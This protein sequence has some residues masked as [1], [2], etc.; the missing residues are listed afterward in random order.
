MLMKLV[1]GLEVSTDVIM[2]GVCEGSI[3]PGRPVVA[4]GEGDFDCD[5]ISDS[6]QAPIRDE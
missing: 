5:H 1:R 2:L 4:V 6:L 3:E